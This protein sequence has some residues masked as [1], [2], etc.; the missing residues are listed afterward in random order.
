[1]TDPLQVG[2]VAPDFTLQNVHGEPVTLS[3]LR[4]KPVAIVFFPFAFSGI[5]TGELCELRD[6]IE[7]FDQ[8][9]VTLLAISCDSV[10]SLKAWAD[11]E[12]YSF[13]LLSDFWPHGEVSRAYGVFDEKAGLAVRGTFLLDGDGVVRWSVVNQPGEARDFGAYQAAIAGL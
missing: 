7:I 2:D 3:S 10:F 9:G 6:H 13:D 12:G 1:M 11:Q 4:G 5:C 8:A